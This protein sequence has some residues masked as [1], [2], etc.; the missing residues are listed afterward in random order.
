MTGNKYII[1][2]LTHDDYR[3]YI[4]AHRLP[5]GSCFQA[6]TEDEAQRTVDANAKW[7]IPVRVVQTPAYQARHRKGAA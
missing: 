3:E 5:P 2:S 6:V 7:G 1:V 4:R